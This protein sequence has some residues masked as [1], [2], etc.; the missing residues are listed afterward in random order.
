MSKSP[1]SQ[2]ATALPARSSAAAVAAPMPPAAPVTMTR[3]PRG[4]VAALSPLEAIPLPVAI[5]DVGRVL[6]PVPGAG[7]A[8]VVAGR[9][10]RVERVAD[11]ADREDLVHERAVGAVDGEAGAV[12]RPVV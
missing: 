9:V 7:I 2:P 11:P 10:A 4:P 8:V 5:G 6:V 1:M 3:R 12:V